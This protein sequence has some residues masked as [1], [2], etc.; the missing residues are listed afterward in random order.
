MG[1]GRKQFGWSAMALAAMA[2]MAVIGCGGSESGSVSQGSSSSSG[3]DVAAVP[4]VGPAV[5][6]PVAV[7]STSDQGTVPVKVLR[8]SLPP[9][10]SGYATE[11]PV[12][13]G[14]VVEVYAEGS[15]DVTGVT[16]WD[17]LGKR[18]AMTFDPGANLWRTYYRVPLKTSSDRIALSVTATTHAQRWRR[19]WV[20]LKLESTAFIDSTH[21]WQG[22]EGEAG[23]GC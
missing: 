2:S 7:A 16:L 19:V 18:Q 4:A 20:F 17:G 9:E 21:S 6:P 22:E 1:F 10:V 3:G 14:S 23:D 13:R 11:D 5:T 8:D 15:P 12:V